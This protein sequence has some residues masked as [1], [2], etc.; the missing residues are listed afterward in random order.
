MARATFATA[1]RL[2]R[3][4]AHAADMLGITGVA[5]HDLIGARLRQV[6]MH[7]CPEVAEALRH[8]GTSPAP[9]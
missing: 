8:Y 1:R 4:N 9:Q 7:D 2:H 5:T 6:T 3:A